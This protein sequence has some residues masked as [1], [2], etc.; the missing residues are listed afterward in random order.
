MV[1]GSA[2][3]ADGVITGQVRNAATKAPVADV[4]I[5]VTSP[6]LQGEQIVVTDA[7]GNFRIPQ[8]APGEGYTVRAD[9]EQYKPFSR[10]GIKLTSGSTVRVNLELLPENIQ[11]GEEIVVVGKPPVIDVGSSRVAVTIDS[12]F[13]RRVAV[14]P[15]AAKGGA[16][17]SF[18][19]LAAVAPGANADAYGVSVNGTSSPENGF[20]IDGVSANDPAFG[21]LAV[22][23]SAEFVKEVN[24]ITAGYLPEYGRSIGGVM[25]VV[26]KSGS[27]EFHGSVFGAIT[28][29]AFEGARTLIP[30][31]GNT[32]NT[33]PTLGSVRDF[34]FEIGGPIVKDK[35]WFFAGFSVAMQRYRLERVLS[36][37]NN[38]IA[39]DLMPNP[40][41]DPE[42]PTSKEFIPGQDGVLEV[43]PTIDASTGYQ[44]ATPLAGVN[45]QVY[46]ADQQTMQY[47]GKLTWNINQDHNISVTVFGAPST[48]G[49]NGTFGFDAQDGGIAVGNLVGPYNSLAG[50]VDQFNNSVVIK[51][52]SAFA[53]KKFLIDATLGWVYNSIAQG[54]AD[55]SNVNDINDPTKLAYMPGMTWRRTSGG[56]H[57]ITDFENLPDSARAQCDPTGDGQFVSNFCPVATYRTGGPGLMNIA[58]SNR[59][60]GRVIATAL[61][62]ALGQHVIKAGVDFEILNYTNTKGYGGGVFFRESTSGNFVADFRRYGFLQGPDDVVN[63]DVFEATSTSTTVGG[64]IQDSWNILDRVTVNLGVRYDAQVVTGNDGNVGIALPNQWSPRIGAIW[65]PTREGRAKITANFARFYQA[66]TLNMVDRSFPGEL[67]LQK[68]RSLNAPNFNP[69]KNGVCNPLDPVQARGPECNSVDNLATYTFEYDP[70]QKYV[71]TGSDRVPIDPD[72]KPQSSDQIVIG[73]EYEII[74]D[75]RIG[76]AYTRQWLNYAMEDMSRDEASTYFIG[77]PGYGIA[78]DFPKATRDYDSFM[79]YFQKAFS[80]QWLA[81]VNYTVSWNRGNLAG[82]FRPETGQLDPN[83]NSDFDLVSILANRTGDLPGDRRHVIKVFGAKEFQLPA[84]VTINLGLGYL[85]RSG[86]PLNVLGSHALYGDSEVFILPRGAGGRTPWVHSIDTNVTF[87]YRFSKDSTLTVGVDIFNL[88]NFQQATGFDQRYTLGDVLPVQDGTAA[89]LH[90]KKGEAPTDTSKKLLNSDGTDFD[91]ADIN[92]NWQNPTS[93][94][95]PRQIRINARVTF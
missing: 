19:S 68:N 48:S 89:N 81:Q 22:P 65:D 8:L 50:T 57:P 26:T 59:Y 53:N 46:Y 87:G 4:V 76:G 30:R 47:I 23:L 85:G 38:R 74:T 21:I 2:Y 64:F 54:A 77:N 71:V 44:T 52:S 67:G 80:N 83:I 55:G 5:T 6:A 39:D 31:A 42:D 51:S 62:S 34:G 37:L 82:L 9:K 69:P 84:N 72:L 79:V 28:P 10:G 70:N 1:A 7:G 15:P 18:E 58:T 66:I 91:P 93:Y 63:L 95:T 60:Q 12:E 56:A 88:F 11:A 32:I 29:G 86:T 41:Y 92:P 90:G 3:A 24:V 36:S 61:L 25:D 16:T 35:L 94:Q 27:N 20:I 40:N 43:Y 45:P 17:R 49:G 73:G 14:N 78:K 75:S 33:N 13:T